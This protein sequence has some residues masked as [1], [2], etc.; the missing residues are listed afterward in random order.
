MSGGRGASSVKY[1]TGCCPNPWRTNFIPVFLC[2][3]VVESV[4]DSGLSEVGAN[5][6]NAAKR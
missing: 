2:G 3:K 5:L 6:N 4:M 1:G